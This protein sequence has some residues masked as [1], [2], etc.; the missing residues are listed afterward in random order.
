MKMM[1][2]EADMTAPL[3][4]KLVSYPEIQKEEIQDDCKR[5]TCSCQ[6]EV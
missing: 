6:E 3:T 5:K 2:E 4:K 1:E